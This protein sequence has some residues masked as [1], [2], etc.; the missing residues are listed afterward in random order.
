MEKN[1]PD[2][3]L[4]EDGRSVV[5][6]RGHRPCSRFA[7][8]GEGRQHLDGVGEP[9]SVFRYDLLRSFLQVDGTPVVSHTLPER[10]NPRE[11]RHREGPEAGKRLDEGGV[12]LQHPLHLCLLEHD[13][14]DEDAVGVAFF[15]PG[16]LPPVLTVVAADNTPEAF[17]IGVRKPGRRARE[18]LSGIVWVLFSHG[19]QDTDTPQGSPGVKGGQEFCEIRIYSVRP[20]AVKSLT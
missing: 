16:E 7:D 12:F 8:P 19:S 10:E 3:G 11:R 18:E 4:D 9:P 15:P 6:E 1:P 20:T 17:E 2:V 5:G 14:G 13:L